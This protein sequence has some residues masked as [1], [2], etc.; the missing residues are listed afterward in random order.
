MSHP[1]MTHRTMKHSSS[2]H[3]PKSK[4]SARK[5]NRGDSKRNAPTSMPTGCT[6]NS[7]KPPDG[8]P[9]RPTCRST[10]RT[11]RSRRG[12]RL[13]W[14][15]C[16]NASRISPAAGHQVMSGREPHRRARASTWPRYCEAKHADRRAKN[17]KGQKLASMKPV[18]RIIEK[19]AQ[20]ARAAIALSTRR[21]RRAMSML[22]K[23]LVAL[24]AAGAMSVPL[25]GV[26][27]ANPPD[28][29][30]SQGQGRPDDPGSNGIGAGGAPQRA[31]TFL[32]SVG[33]NPSGDSNPVPAGSAFEVYAKMPGS[34]PT[35]YGSALNAFALR[36]PGLG[37]P[38]FDVPTPPGLGVK[39]F[40]PGC[41]HGHSTGVCIPV[42]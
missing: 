31:G 40:T 39:I 17:G 22:R 27:W 10:K 15:S 29:P 24:V 7:S 34:T 36:H 33:E 19:S 42:P 4:N 9:T 26:A 14:T 32:G 1:R 37:L 12:S 38:T 2:S 13:R 3:G 25:A 35:V 30:G 41:T 18:G 28:N 11:L 20:A 21:N 6:P 8:S 5:T 23:A 16:C